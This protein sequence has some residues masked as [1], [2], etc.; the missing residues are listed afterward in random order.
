MNKKKV[1]SIFFTNK[2]SVYYHLFGVNF[3]C[4]CANYKQYLPLFQIAREVEL[5]RHLNHQNVVGFHSY[6]EDSD[7]VYIV[8][9]H[10]SRK[11]NIEVDLFPTTRPINPPRVR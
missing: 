3:T 7:N 11:V 4:I 5:H 10:C 9:E 8:L 6:F 2:S 1:L